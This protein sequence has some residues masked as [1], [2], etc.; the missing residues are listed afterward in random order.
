MDEWVNILDFKQYKNEIE[1]LADERRLEAQM[2][3]SK[4]LEKLS[5]LPIAVHL[6]KERK[7]LLGFTLKERIQYGLLKANVKLV[8]K[9]LK[10]M[11]YEV[12]I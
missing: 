2:S 3:K 1:L 4:E 6:A 7:R 10:K 12:E 9:K 11:G 8:K 5:F